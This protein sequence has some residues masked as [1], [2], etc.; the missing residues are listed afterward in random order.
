MFLE[1]KLKLNQVF[2]WD[3]RL[4]YKT[5]SQIFLI[6]REREN[7]TRGDSLPSIRQLKLKLYNQPTC[8]NAFEVS[9]RSLFPR[10]VCTENIAAHT[11]CSLVCSILFPRLL[12][13]ASYSCRR[14]QPFVKLCEHVQHV[15]VKFVLKPSNYFRVIF[16]DYK[17][18]LWCSQGASHI[19][20]LWVLIVGCLP[21]KCI[22]VG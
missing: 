19:K 16:F 7:V 6:K 21:F 10:G 13:P 5:R 17:A 18:C 14:G 1:L 20:F 11:K 3:F 2:I 8:W 4:M 22:F 12:Q 15:F 9:C